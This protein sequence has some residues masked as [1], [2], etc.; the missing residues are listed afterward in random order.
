MGYMDYINC[1][2]NG[3]SAKECENK[4]L[5]PLPPK[6]EE[7]TAVSP[8]PQAAVSSSQEEKKFFTSLFRFDNKHPMIGGADI[9]YGDPGQ[10][11]EQLSE[12][13]TKNSRIFFEK[14]GVDTKEGYEIPK[15]ITQDN[16]FAKNFYELMKDPKNPDFNKS[17]DLMRTMAWQ[18]N[19]LTP[20]E[21][22]TAIFAADLNQNGR[23]DNP[24]KHT[25]YNTDYIG[26]LEFDILYN[27]FTPPQPAHSPR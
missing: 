21:M 5:A 22:G 10:N 12:A 20:E 24:F 11:L 26:A 25:P 18:D 19:I 15:K 27:N 16:R 3:G 9:Y 17:M 4:H 23:I 6:S 2:K 7:Q 1:T 13:A 14:A 8:S